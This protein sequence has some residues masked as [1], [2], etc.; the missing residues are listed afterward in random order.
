MNFFEILNNRRDTRHFL[1][2]EIPQQVLDN[3]FAAAQA[4][5]SVG[6]SQ[7][8]RYYLI[9]KKEIKKSIYQLFD[10]ANTN[11][12]NKIL[13]A[14][15]KKAYNNLKLQG[16][17]DAPL[18]LIIT[19]DY[20]VLDN[21]TIGV[22]G[23]SDALQWSSV[24]AL[25]NFWL[26][27]TADGYS[28]GWVSIL[29]YDGL[30][31]MIDLPSHE[32]PLGYF[33]IGK[34]AT[35]YNNMPMLEKE[36]WKAKKPLIV[37]KIETFNPID[38]YNKEDE[39]R[40]ASNI[41]KKYNGD[42]EKSITQA[43]NQKLKPIGALGKL[44]DIAKQIA[45]IQNTLQ[46]KILNPTIIV[47]AGD[48]GIA[49]TGLV[50]SYPQAVTS[51]MVKNFMCGKAAISVFCTQNN[52]QL[53][54]VDAG[55]NHTF[56]KDTLTENFIDAKINFGTKNY[57]ETKAMSLSECNLSIKKGREITEKIIK[58]NKCNVLGFGEMGIGNSSSA[59]L[60]VSAI[61]KF[62]INDCVGLGAGVDE[63]EYQKKVAV[64]K[65]V[66][67]LHYKTNFT[68]LELLCS[69]GGFEIA[70]MVGA[71]L[72][73][74]D[75]D[76]VILVDGFIATSALLIAKLINPLILNNCIFSHTS[77]EMAHQNVLSYLNVDSLLQFNL[78]LGEGTGSALAMPMLQNAV[79]M[80]NN[81][82]NFDFTVNANQKPK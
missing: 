69:F 55:I 47:F 60:I 28:L 18:G 76:C 16:I 27:L 64:L 7:P 59:A 37:N 51:F 40:Q 23:T 34:P 17:L 2:D 3:A 4:S 71:Y 61:T 49:A 77:S 21:F 72:Q 25:Q 24:C 46:P 32:K 73:A 81:M 1:S 30:K 56:Q 44:E 45:T 22:E 80:L 31:K 53:F 38:L 62:S 10:K 5:P 41:I 67:E 79:A 58:N 33:C 42:F 63:L 48:H 70:M 57:L 15:Q 52:I 6:L 54:V 50:N 35:N 8:T 36:N 75:N 26:S 43:I 11:V 20:S 78:R 19:T 39:L 65:K 82:G 66:Y 14:S 13:N 29:D 74:Y 68:Y 9:S 12:K